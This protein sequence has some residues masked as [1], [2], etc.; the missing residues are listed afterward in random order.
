MKAQQT[1]Q[2]TKTACFMS[3]ESVR[4]ERAVESPLMW[5]PV[6]AGFPSPADDYIERPIDLNRELILHPAAT[7]FVR[8]Q[9]DSMVGAGLWHGDTLIVD[10]AVDPR[11]GHI[12][13]ALLD[14]DF[15]VKRMQK[16]GGV[17]HLVAENPL[18]EAIELT[19][20]RRFEVWG[21]VTWVLHKAV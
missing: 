4:A 16:A 21:V 8:V 1:Q 17:V 20:E 7:F 5:A 13:V 11:D 19:E 14:G 9:G 18:Y 6:A 12:V 15:T 3:M 10:R 2:N